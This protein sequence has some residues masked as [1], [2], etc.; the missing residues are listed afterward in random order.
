M[1]FYFWSPAVEIY[2]CVGSGLGISTFFWCAYYF[3]YLFDGHMGHWICSQF[4]LGERW[5]TPWTDWQ[6]HSHLPNLRVCGRKLEKTHTKMQTERQC[7]C[8]PSWDKNRESSSLIWPIKFDMNL[9]SAFRRHLPWE[10]PGCQSPPQHISCDT[11]L[12][13][14][15]CYILNHWITPIPGRGNPTQRFAGAAES[16]TRKRNINVRL[17]DTGVVAVPS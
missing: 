13:R 11:G 5:G 7:V 14:S 8:A 1:I 12:K 17:W 10:I 4:T 6:S 2:T 9:L 15:H 3:Y 16:V